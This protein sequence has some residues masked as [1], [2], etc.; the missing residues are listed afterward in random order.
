MSKYRTISARSIVLH[1]ECDE[2]QNSAGRGNYT[3]F[4]RTAEGNDRRKSNYIEVTQILEGMSGMLFCR[5]AQAALTP[6]PSL[7][8]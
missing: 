5:Y 1:T 3:F 2:P 6:L 8:G 4:T 7:T